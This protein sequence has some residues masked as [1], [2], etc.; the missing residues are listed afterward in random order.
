[1][2]QRAACSVQRTVCRRYPAPCRVLLLLR[3]WTTESC[4]LISLFDATITLHT[5]QVECDC[6]GMLRTVLSIRTRK[7]CNMVSSLID[8]NPFYFQTTRSLLTHSQSLLYASLL[9]PGLAR[10]PPGRFLGTSG[11]LERLA[12]CHRTRFFG[13][14]H[15]LARGIPA[16]PA[17]RHRQHHRQHRQYP[18][19]PLHLLP[20]VRHTV[21]NSAL[22]GDHSAP[23]YSRCRWHTVPKLLCTH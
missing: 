17:Q 5:S 2:C 7:V 8:S 20:Q 16:V 1:M 13:K 11:P 15:F 14:W 9:V 4:M 10:T 22:C 21:C 6:L 3:V 19:R 18:L 23:I 12:T